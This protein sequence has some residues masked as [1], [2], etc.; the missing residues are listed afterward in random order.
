MSARVTGDQVKLAVVSESLLRKRLMS[1]KFH[2]GED[3]TIEKRCPRCKDYWPADSE[4]FY[5]TGDK[6]DG[7]TSWCKACYIEW[8]YPGG[9]GSV[10]HQVRADASK[11]AE[12]H[13]N[14]PHYSMALTTED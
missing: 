1:G 10:D 5:S 9:R 12:F 11:K 13:E 6:G 8:R 2:I 4:F 14:E 7:L 3:G